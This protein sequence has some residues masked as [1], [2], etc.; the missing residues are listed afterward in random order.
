LWHKPPWKSPNLRIQPGRSPS[1]STAKAGGHTV[2]HSWPPPIHSRSMPEAP[3]KTPYARIS[4]ACIF[5]KR[6]LARTRQGTSRRLAKILSRGRR[7]QLSPATQTVATHVHD[8]QGR[9]TRPRRR[10]ASGG[11]PTPS[12]FQTDFAD[13]NPSI[14]SSSL[15]ADAKR[16]PCPAPP[17]TANHQTTALQPIGRPRRAASTWTTLPQYGIS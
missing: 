10:S 2:F 16:Q 15:F 8:P 3:T 1:M 14:L 11:L 13:E 12:T 17:V 9:D 7:Q 5:R 4:A 6:S